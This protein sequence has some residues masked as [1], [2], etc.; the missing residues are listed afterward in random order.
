MFQLYYFKATFS[1]NS[2]YHVC[3]PEQARSGTGRTTLHQNR[4]KRWTTPSTNIWQEPGWE[5]NS[6]TKH[7]V[8][9]RRG[10]KRGRKGKEGK[11]KYVEEELGE[12][13]FCPEPDPRA[14]HTSF[15]TWFGLQPQPRHQLITIFNLKHLIG[16]GEVVGGLGGSVQGAKSLCD[17]GR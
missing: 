4:A 17:K 2:S 9:R 8:S 10:S 13:L 5:P 11:G 14:L 12:G 15:F 1:R 7:T 6:T 16:R 3:V